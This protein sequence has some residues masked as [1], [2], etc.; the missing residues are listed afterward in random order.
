M[1]VGV[2]GVT[3]Q[4]TFDTG[5]TASICAS[6][7]LKSPDDKTICAIKVSNGNYEYSEGKTTVQV[8]LGT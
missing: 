4:G 2:D 3:R 7:P 6:R 8:D 5:A 1:D